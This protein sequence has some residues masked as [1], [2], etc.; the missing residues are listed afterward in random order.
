M[1]GRS[2][3]YPHAIRKRRPKTQA[4]MYNAVK[5]SP[6]RHEQKRGFS[7]IYLRMI[8]IKFNIKSIYFVARNN[9]NNNIQHVYMKVP[10][11]KGYIKFHSELDQGVMT[12]KK[13][14]RNVG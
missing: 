13:K 9:N 1:N 7:H 6:R 8:K 14:F 10:I 12:A 11:L 5:R 3:R 2:K 4:S